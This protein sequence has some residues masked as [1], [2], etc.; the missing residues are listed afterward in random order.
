MLRVTL[1]RLSSLLRT[2]NRDDVA[3]FQDGIFTY[4]SFIPRIH[5]VEE[6]LAE[7][8]VDDVGELVCGGAVGDQI[9]VG[10]DAAVVVAEV[11]DVLHG[12]HDDHVKQLVVGG[13]E[14]VLDAG[15]AVGF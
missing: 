2:H 9:R 6:A 14:R 4:P 3:V 5:G 11:F 8:G 12:V 1:P 7:F 10:E 13:V 15:G